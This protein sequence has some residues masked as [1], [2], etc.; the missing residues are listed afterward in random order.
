MLSLSSVSVWLWP[1]VFLQSICLYFCSLCSDWLLS[2][3]IRPL[4]ATSR[5][6][7]MLTSPSQSQSAW[8]AGGLWVIRYTVNQQQFTADVFVPLQM[9]CECIPLVNVCLPVCAC[10]CLCWDAHMVKDSSCSLFVRKSKVKLNP[11]SLFLWL[12]KSDRLFSW[13]LYSRALPAVWSWQDTHTTQ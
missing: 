2:R 5:H 13:H 7:S 9:M 6:T 8:G 4:Q 11:H 3:P 12:V 10:V 1:E